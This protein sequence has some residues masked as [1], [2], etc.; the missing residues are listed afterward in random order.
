MFQGKSH[1]QLL[2]LK[3]Q[4]MARI[5]SGKAGVDIG[6]WESLLQQLN[7]H[8]ARARLRERHQEKLRNKLLA[9]REQVS[10]TNK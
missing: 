6:Y 3:G 9:L 2:A 5:K 4:I 8:M 10:K 7:A 1:G